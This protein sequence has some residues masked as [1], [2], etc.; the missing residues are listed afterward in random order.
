MSHP[1]RPW[2]LPSLLL[3]AA[4]GAACGATTD[5]EAV[6]SETEHTHVDGTTHTHDDEAAPE[7]VGLDLGL[8]LDGAL[9]DDPVIEDC[10]LTDGTTA[11]CY[12]I[13]VVGT[14]VNHEV[15]PFCSADVT[16]GEEAGGLWL[17]GED[18]YVID[19]A[20]FT[21]LAE[22]YGDDLWDNL[23]DDDGSIN[24]IDNAAD[25]QVAARPD[26]TEEFYFHCVDG[27][28]AWL[29]SG[30]QPTTTIQV[31]VTPVTTGQATVDFAAGAHSTLGVTLNGATLS[32]SAD[33]T[34]ILNGHTS[35]AYGYHYH[36]NPLELNA[37]L[38][39]LT[40][41]TVEGQDATGRPGGGRAG[42]PPPGDNG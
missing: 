13:T 24:V 11:S 40:G 17:D 28:V 38:T 33:V 18:S 27:D 7:H 2:I 25:F 5:A 31:P 29:D 16:D 37:T 22:I 21:Q 30:V 36:A 4:I 35:E 32:G 39:C 12:T 26:I 23:V 1:L 8:F 14:P 3:L 42:G 6:S 10:T 15:G 9:V 34:A 19:G 20:F 41:L